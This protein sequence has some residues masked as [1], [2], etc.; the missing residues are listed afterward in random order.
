MNRLNKILLLLI[1]IVFILCAAMFLDL[2][3]EDKMAEINCQGSGKK[4]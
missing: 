1:V 3:L 2:Y 4:E